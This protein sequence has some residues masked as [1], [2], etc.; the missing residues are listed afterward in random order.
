MEQELPLAAGVEFAHA[1]AQALANLDQLDVLHIKGPAVH[2]ALLSRAGAGEELTDH[3]RHSM[4][5]DVLVRPSQAQALIDRLKEHGWRL[6]VPFSGGSSFEHAATLTHRVMAPLDVHRCF[7]GVGIDREVAFDILWRARTVQTIGGIDCWVPSLAAQRLI[8]L[9]N[10]ARG[11]TRHSDVVTT[12]ELGSRAER[13]QV[14]DLAAHLD[15]EVALAAALGELDGYTGRREHDLWQV[16]SAGTGTPLRLWWAHVKAE[17]NV[18]A[19][20]RRGVVLAFPKPDRMSR[21]AG[22][23]LRGGELVWAYWSRLV[24]ASRPL[25]MRAQSLFRRRGR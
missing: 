10:T 8:L 12:W 5:A 17:D 2:P 13:Q 20:I 3:P 18:W 23:E 15:A 11:A 4:D 9:L 7:P 24:T 16:L 1:S 6:K 14:R 22:H 25:G 19:A 21:A